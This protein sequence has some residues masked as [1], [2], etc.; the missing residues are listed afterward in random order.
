MTMKIQRL[1]NYYTDENTYLVYDGNTALVIDPGYKTDGILKA[2]ADAK[3]TIQYILITHC[4]YDHIEFME[5]LREKTNAKLVSGDKA[6]INITDP[7]INLTLAGL[8]KAVSAKKSDIILKDGETLP[9]G[10]MQ[11]KCIYTPGHTNCGT[12]YLIE[13]HLFSGDT[14][15][16]RNCG[17]WDLPTGDEETLIRSVK[18][19]IY[20]LDDEIII[21]PGHGE[22]TTVGYEKKFNLYIKE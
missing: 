13:N 16:L 3:T 9:V 8:G 18:N 10:N 22:Q 2:A 20:T 7:D 4:H 21:H 17:R 1:N 11:V 19:K 6:S 5:D 14:L 12:C 15:F